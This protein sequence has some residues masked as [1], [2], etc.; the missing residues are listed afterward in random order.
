VAISLSSL[1][2]GKVSG[3]ALGDE[4]RFH[5]SDVRLIHGRG[6]LRPETFFSVDQS[7]LEENKIIRW[8]GVRVSYGP[9]NKS[10]CYRF[11][12]VTHFSFFYPIS[13]P[14]KRL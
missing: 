2:T 5:W 14:S 10:S 4:Y 6:K 1:N 7:S 13:T 8:S 12:P 9:S 3:V 11:Q